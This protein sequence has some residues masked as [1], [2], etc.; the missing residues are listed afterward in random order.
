[1]F[2]GRIQRAEKKWEEEN[3]L[4]KRK[5]EREQADRHAKREDEKRKEESKKR[6][7]LIDKGIIKYVKNIGLVNTETGK[8]I[9]L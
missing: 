9:K 1:M 7:E 2:T 4:R 5:F 6:K 3:K 8:V